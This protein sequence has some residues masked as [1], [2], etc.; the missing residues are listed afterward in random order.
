VG[1]RVVGDVLPVVTF[2]GVLRGTPALIE[3]AAVSRR[4]A[5][6]VGRYLSMVAGL[7]DGRIGPA[8]FRARVR[9]WRP[10][11]V[12]DPAWGPVP[13]VSDP[14]TVIVLATAGQAQEVETWIDSGRR[15]MPRRGRT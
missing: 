15:R 2:F 7:L 10:V 6:R 9:H 14:A 11:N 8:A 5:S 12:L 4:D 3:Q 1:Q 13:F